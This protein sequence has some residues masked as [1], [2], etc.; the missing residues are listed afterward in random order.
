MKNRKRDK[1]EVVFKI[2]KGMRKEKM[3]E[4]RSLII[5]SIFSMIFLFITLTFIIE[6]IGKN[7]NYLNFI[8]LMFLIYCSYKSCKFLSHEF[9]NLEYE[10][11][12]GK[13]SS[14]RSLERV[15]L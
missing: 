2:D 9:S 6:I 14:S 10:V 5:G 1:K 3:I 11:K 8:C 12:K 7:L 13:N 4:K 15:R